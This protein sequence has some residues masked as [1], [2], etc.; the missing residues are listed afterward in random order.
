MPTICVL[1][2]PV[3][4]LEQAGFAHLCPTVGNVE[5]EG[6]DPPL[7]NDVQQDLYHQVCRALPH[8]HHTHHEGAGGP[9][10]VLHLPR[11]SPA[12]DLYPQHVW[13]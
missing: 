2:Q 1:P 9:E 6:T 13:Q 11:V 7:T 12:S 3:R 10:S 5:L 4:P 8:T